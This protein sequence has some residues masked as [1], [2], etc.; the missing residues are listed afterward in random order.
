MTRT[1][2]G[3]SLGRP[4]YVVIADWR[5]GRV[6]REAK[7]LVPS[8]WNWAH[9]SPNGSP[10]FAELAMVSTRAPDP[11]MTVIDG[12]VVRRLAPDSRKAELSDHPG[13]QLQDRVLEKL[14]AKNTLLQN[15]L[16]EAWGARSDRCTPPPRM[17]GLSKP[18]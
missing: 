9:C 6:V 16:L 14:E 7:A 4:R 18:T 5:G 2:G 17:S 11:Y 12:F 1:A 13:A 8:A 10:R 3:G 15:K